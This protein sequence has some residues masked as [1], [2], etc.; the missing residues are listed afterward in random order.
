MDAF[1]ERLGLLTK[2]ACEV[3][4]AAMK[5]QRHGP[6]S[7]WPRDTGVTNREQLEQ[8]CGHILFA[9]DFLCSRGDLRRD[10]VERWKQEKARTIG[11][12][13]HFQP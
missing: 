12:W 7:R 5:I 2:E 11:Q 4:Q 1:L 3:G 10:E 6:A 13:L 8:E 9:I